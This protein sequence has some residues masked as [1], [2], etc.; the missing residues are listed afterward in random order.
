VHA[1]LRP[2]ATSAAILVATVAI[3]QA[4]S[5]SGASARQPDRPVAAAESNAAADHVQAPAEAQGRYRRH[6]GRWW[7]WLPENRWVVWQRGA[8]VPYAPGM[9]ADRGV[10]GRSTQRYSYDSQP[11][12]YSRGYGAPRAFGSSRSIR[13]AGSKINF[14]YLP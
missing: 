13:Y 11:L 12:G 10:I 3:S 7:Y 9:F 6:N 4:Q 14:D 5:R 8:W 1:L 2:A